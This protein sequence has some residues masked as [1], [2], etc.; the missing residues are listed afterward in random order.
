[1]RIVWQRG[2]RD[3]LKTIVTYI[4]DDNP[5]AAM[6]IYQVMQAQV[7]H[8]AEFPYFGREGRVEGT[9]ELVIANLPYIVAYYLTGQEIRILAVLHTSRKWPES[10][11]TE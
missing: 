7:K 8:L 10:F 6:R 1:M 4:R 5:D 9:R 11:P 2:A 3:D